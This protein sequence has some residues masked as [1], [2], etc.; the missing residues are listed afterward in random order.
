MDLIVQIAMTVCGVFTVALGVVHV[1]MP[2]LL[3]FRG[4]IPAAG[5]PLL[6]LRLGPIRYATTRS[7]VRGIAWVMNHAASYVLIS[8]GLADLFWWKWSE[9]ALGVI[10]ALWIAGWWLLRAGTQLYLGRRRGDLQIAAGFAT[11]AAVHV[12][13]AFLG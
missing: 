7:D 8:I 1:F 12:A 11:L 6:P 2:T 10:L 9:G 3:D 4:A 13:A 5:D